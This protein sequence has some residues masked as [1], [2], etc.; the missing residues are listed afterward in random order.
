MAFDK[1][2]WKPT[3]KQEQFLSLPTTIFEGLYGGGNASGKSD[4]LLVYGIIHRWHENPRFK[5]VFMRRTYPELRNEIV[6]RSREIYPKFGATFN[7]TEM[8]W[9]FPRL[10]QY[11]GTGMSNQG[12]LIFLAHCEEEDDVHKYDSM[13]I[14]LFTPDELTTFTEYMYL[15]IGFTRVR[16]SDTTLPAIIRAAGMPGG[17]GH[18]FTKRRFVAPCP[19]GNKIIIGKGNVK[20]IYI[21]ATVADNEYADPG[22]TARLDGLNEADRKAR[23]FGDWDAYQGQVFDEFRDKKY[24]DEPENA[25]HTITPYIIPDWWPKLVV[26]DWGYT[27]MTYIGFY[28]I[29][30]QKR[31][32][33]YRE[34]YWVKTKIED[35]APVIKDYIDR[36]NPR[37]I[38]FCKSAG[39]EHGQE[40]TIQ[41][42]IET[43]LGH[44]IEL[45]V[46]SPGSR[47]A[48]KMLVHE[49]LRWAQKP[50][51]PVQDMPIYSEEYAMYLLR[52][53]SQ[54]DYNSYL[55]LFKPPEIETNIPKL[56]IMK[57]EETVH[58]GHPN[59]CPV[60]IEALKA[61]IYAKPKDNKPAEDVAEFDGDD[62]YDD[63]RYAVDSAERYF[64]DA[65]V[66]FERIKK[67]AELTETLNNYHDWTGYYRNMH[68][69]EA[70]PKMQVVSRFHHR[71]M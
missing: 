9:T 15:Y 45:S 32:I 8:C 5:Q 65:S 71:R 56:L 69:I 30:P 66:E 63:I 57:C 55:A 2:L 4:V 64:T 44:P 27:A 3:H 14:N 12:A 7:R 6:P 1:G 59:C 37:V 29:S 52:N 51:I 43:A 34:L 31:L 50:I 60:M 11:G 61:C 68:Q 28:A 18:T 39:Q 46:N 54:A 41:Q 58:L 38:K 62:P 70:V 20:R 24:P 33:L 40:H 53:K 36:E 21:H 49:Y 23:K 25:I 42:Q 13:E 10:D 48:G 17:I 35:W 19:E 67:Q 16:T 47:I 22:Y 26:G